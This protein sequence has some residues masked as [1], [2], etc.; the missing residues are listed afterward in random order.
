MVEAAQPTAIVRLLTI[1]TVPGAADASSS[2]RSLIQVLVVKD[3]TVGDHIM[4][5]AS[6]TLALLQATFTIFYDVASDIEL[7]VKTE[8]SGCDTP[9]P[10]CRDA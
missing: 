5:L 2:P 9:V 6:Q 3:N 8:S 4:W 10:T 7:N 1:R